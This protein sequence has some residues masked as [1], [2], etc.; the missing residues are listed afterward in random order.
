MVTHPFVTEMGDGSLPVAK[1]R[2]YFLQDYVFINDLVSI[3]ALGMSKAPD[4]AAASVL[5]DFL[6]GILNP[7]NDLFVSAFRELGASE[8][9]YSSAVASPTT[10]A[11]GDFLLRT[12]L[13]GDFLDIVTVL[14]VTEATYLDWAT[15][16]IRAG[17]R[18]ENPVYRQWIDLHGPDALGKLVAWLGDHMDGADLSS[19]RPR[20]E[21][22]FLTALRY[23][24]R[25]WEA[26][27]SGEQWEGG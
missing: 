8:A 27:Y 19:R 9:E 16:L 17:S 2:A 1:F 13:E 14:Y 15:R 22:L 3:T 6:T 18:P 25:F 5:N 20:I 7:E 4:L 26:A 10:Q 12:S 24:Y 11:F 23:E 21:R